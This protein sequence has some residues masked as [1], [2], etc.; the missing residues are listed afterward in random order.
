MSGEPGNAAPLAGSHAVETTTQIF[1]QDAMA[2]AVVRE[3][4]YDAGIR[5]AQFVTGDI[6]AAISALAHTHS[7]DLLFVEVKGADDPLLRIKR[8]LDVCEPQTAVVL[9]GERNDVDLYRRLKAEGVV[10]YYVKPLSKDLVAPLCQNILSGA[11]KPQRPHGGK[12][13]LILGVRGGVG[14]TTISVNTAWNL[15]EPGKHQTVL[16]DLDLKKGD[17]ALQLDTRSNSGLREALEH[18][19]RVD[20]QFL[21]RAII[22]VDHRIDLLASPEDYGGSVVFEESAVLALLKALLRRYQFVVVDVP[23]DL[24]PALPAVLHLPSLC[25]LVSNATLASARDVAR[26]RTIVGPDTPN[27]HT[28]H[29]LN[30]HGLAGG[31]PDTEFTRA[32]GKA[33]DIVIAQDSAI[34]AA[35]MIGLKGLQQ[36]SPLR[37]KLAPLLNIVLDGNLEEQRSLLGRLF[38]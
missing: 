36:G 17:A 26:L 1:M 18:P 21:D 28:L 16:V 13:A 33:P 7:P 20:K 2:E 22:D 30:Q 4:L 24:A 32:A 34:G 29:I 19:E 3:C 6:G 9:I 38:G 15:G 31:L 35:S 37:R 8:L 14:A 25:V 12:L 10:E 27:R 23:P 11:V 5:S